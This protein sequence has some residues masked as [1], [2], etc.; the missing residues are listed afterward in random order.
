[1]SRF[2]VALTNTTAEVKKRELLFS[3]LL[4]VR[5]MYDI[6]YIKYILMCL[7]DEKEKNLSNNVYMRIGLHNF[8]LHF[9]SHSCICFGDTPTQ[10]MP[11]CLNMSARWQA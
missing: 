10:N 8:F 11:A 4:I 9:F 3:S 6:K 2:V 7:L 1:M 5:K